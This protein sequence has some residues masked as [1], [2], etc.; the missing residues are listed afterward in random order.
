MTNA[1]VKTKK[2]MEAII[3]PI[4]DCLYYCEE[5]SKIYQYKDNNW[6]EV[7]TENKGL[8]MKLYDLNK[9]IMSQM[10][11][12]TKK[13]IKN[14]CKEILKD[15]QEKTPNTYYMLLCKE[16][17][18]YTLFVN[19]GITVCTTIGHDNLPATLRDIV[20]ELGEVY[21]IEP[22]EDKYAIEIW[23]KPHD[24]EEPLAFYF[25]NYQQGVVYYE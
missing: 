7:K 10:P 4:D 1:I 25:F 23:I 18:Y 2:E 12:L 17:N 15:Y 6:E 16:Y 3:K 9:N 8:E 24:V 20:S 21:S 14:K 22:T 11:P 19:D 13:E 5:D